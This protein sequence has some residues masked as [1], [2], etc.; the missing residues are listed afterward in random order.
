[1]KADAPASL[2]AIQAVASALEEASVRYAF[3]GVAALNARGVPRATFDLD[4]ALS[5]PEARIRHLASELP[6]G[7][8]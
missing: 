6:G 7:A 3:I 2:E 5:I 1:L 8:A 4:L